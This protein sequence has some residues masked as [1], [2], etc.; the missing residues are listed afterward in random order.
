[1]NKERFISRAVP[2]LTE[3]GQVRVDEKAAIQ[4]GISGRW[5]I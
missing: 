5:I 1:L 4:G 2:D 3:V